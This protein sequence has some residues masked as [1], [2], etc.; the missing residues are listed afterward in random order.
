[1][2]E[3]AFLDQL[4][5]SSPISMA[6]RHKISSLLQQSAVLERTNLLVPGQRAQKMYYLING[7]AK[8]C[9]YHADGRENIFRLYQAG[10]IITDTQSF[11]NEKPSTRG[12]STLGPCNF[13]VLTKSAY[14]ELSPYPETAKLTARFLIKE[15]CLASYRADFLLLSQADKV[16]Y[17][18]KYYDAHYFYNKESA[19][20][21]QMTASN[22]CRQKAL[23]NSKK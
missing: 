21:L 8:A 13:L 16:A 14:Q 4:H 5:R 11:F 23:Y 1:M 17:F 7:Y 10:Q 18:F 15:Q 20:F 3:Q 19:S 9:T 12:I 22:Y 6:Y 2:E